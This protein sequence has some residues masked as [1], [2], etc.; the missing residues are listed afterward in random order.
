M[1]IRNCIAIVSIS[2][3]PTMVPAEETPTEIFARYAKDGSSE[4]AKLISEV[5][6][7]LAGNE[8]VAGA[9]K[10]NVSLTSISDQTIW[11]A[12]RKVGFDQA[13]F[14]AKFPTL[15]EYEQVILVS[16]E[17]HGLPR[18][19]YHLPAG[20]KFESPRMLC[21]DG[22]FPVDASTVVDV[23]EWN[24][25]AGMLGWEGYFDCMTVD[26]VPYVV[27]KTSGRLTYGATAIR[28]IWYWMRVGRTELIP[29][30]Y[31]G[32]MVP[33]GGKPE[34]KYLKDLMLPSRPVAPGAEKR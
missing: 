11:A 21:G 27:R 3:L 24:D 25:S 8:A 17:L 4:F 23:G 34:P 6:S 33:E 2:L 10:N 16:K 15:A 13:A 32:Y 20:I 9:L 12:A 29:D 31:E 22:A 26:G 5:D 30:R 1:N 14:L 7:V 28:H 18:V 19:I